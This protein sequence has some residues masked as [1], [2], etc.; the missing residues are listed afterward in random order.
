MKRL[1]KNLRIILFVLTICVVVFLNVA[2]EVYENKTG[3]KVSRT[4]TFLLPIGLAYIIIFKTGSNFLSSQVKETNLKMK[5]EKEAEEKIK[6]WAEIG[7][8]FKEIDY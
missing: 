2:L 8:R 6:D 4:L 7:G 1:K 5:K 3:V